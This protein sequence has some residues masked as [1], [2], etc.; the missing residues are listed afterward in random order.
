VPPGDSHFSAYFRG[1]AREAVTFEQVIVRDRSIKLTESG[2]DGFQ[3]KYGVEDFSKKF[4]RTGLIERLL[5]YPG[6]TD[7]LVQRRRRGNPRFAAIFF[8]A[9]VLLGLAWSRAD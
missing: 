6:K 8:F 2:G 5:G 1:L 4:W 9:T 7:R 3:A